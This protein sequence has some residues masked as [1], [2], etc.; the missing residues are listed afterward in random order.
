[1]EADRVATLDAAAMAGDAEG[2]GNGGRGRGGGGGEYGN[3]DEV[4]DNSGDGV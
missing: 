4:G 3:S 2:G 1:V